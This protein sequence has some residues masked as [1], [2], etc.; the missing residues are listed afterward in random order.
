VSGKTIAESGRIIEA[1]GSG[2]VVSGFFEIQDSADFVNSALSTGYA[3]GAQ[4]VNSSTSG[5][6][7]EAVIGELTFNGSGSV[8]S[9]STLEYADDV[10]VGW[11]SLNG[12]GSISVLVDENDGGTINSMVSQ[13]GAYTVSSLGYLQ[14]S[15]VENHSPNFYLYAPGAGYGMTGDTSVEFLYLQPQT[16]PSG[17]FTTASISGSYALGTI[18]PASYSSS[19]TGVTS[20]EAFLFVMDYP[21]GKDPSLYQLDHQCSRARRCVMLCASVH[22][23]VMLVR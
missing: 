12:S 5:P 4:N 18:P 11:A 15:G 2:F 22:S 13:T 7:R 23:F 14:L 3:F 1:D 8:T 9:S 16:I 20:G 10:V 21:S 17:G 6:A 19:G